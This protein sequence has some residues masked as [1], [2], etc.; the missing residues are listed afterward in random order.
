MSRAEYMFVNFGCAL[1]TPVYLQLFSAF[2]AVRRGSVKGDIA[3]RIKPPITT[4][5]KAMNWRAVFS[6]C[7]VCLW[8]F[9]R[10]PYYFIGGKCVGRFNACPLSSFA[11]TPD[12]KESGPLSV[13]SR[14]GPPVQSGTRWPR[15]T[16]TCPF[17][18]LVSDL[19]W[20]CR[21]NIV[22]PESNPFSPRIRDHRVLPSTEVE[23]TLIARTP[24]VH[25]SN[26]ASLASKVA[27]EG[28]E[29][30]WS[31]L[32]VAGC[33]GRVSAESL[34]EARYGRQNCTPVQCF[35]RRGDER[36][37]AYMGRAQ[38]LQPGGHLNIEVLRAVEGEARTEPNL[39]LRSI[40]ELYSVSNRTGLSGYGNSDCF[41]N[42][43]NIVEVVLLEW[44]EYGAAA[45]WN[46][47]EKGDPRENPPI[48]GIVRHD[49][50][51]WKSGCDLIEDP[52]R[53]AGW[54]VVRLPTEPP[55]GW[56]VVRLPT[57]PP[58]GWRV[59]RLPTESPAGW[60]VVRLP[61]EPPA[62][63]RVVRLP[64]E[65]PAG[66]RVVRLPTEPPAGWRVVRLPTEPP[67]GWRV[68]RLPTEPPAGWRVVRL[69]TEPPAGWRAVRLP[70]EPPA[71]W[72]A[73]RLPTE[74]PAGWRAVRLPTEP[75]RLV[76]P[77][78]KKRRSA[79][80]LAYGV[81]SVQSHALCHDG[82]RAR[83]PQADQNANGGGCKLRVER[84]H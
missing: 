24:A 30:I 42:N 50:H 59:V 9:Q 39:L 34:I 44:G 54:R 8:D 70:T 1:K 28:C 65:P 21:R 27:S 45:E 32:N 62:G 66:W 71:G 53:Q 83:V 23:N 81:A 14:A 19:V 18:T 49:S 11:S 16:I 48:S 33:V 77:P 25:S 75:P 67:A 84:T 57:E 73:V 29:E 20:G 41:G 80:F 2:E 13:V 26:M 7:C 51:V 68:V 63:W 31:A 37:D 43:P 69:P 47:G 61:T 38:F 22:T 56:R 64:T 6:S 3:T 12:R 58:A 35:E 76:W 55:A 10:R 72:R 74:P 78:V 5:R 46:C 52:V 4:K 40:I 79:M 60:R 17:Y 15:A 82:Q 36:V